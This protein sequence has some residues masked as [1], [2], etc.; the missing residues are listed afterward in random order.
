MAGPFG[1]PSYLFIDRSGMDWRE[2]LT[3]VLPKQGRIGVRAVNFNGVDPDKDTWIRRYNDFD[4][5]EKFRRC[6]ER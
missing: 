4:D 2:F 5:I 6:R 1:A 3:I